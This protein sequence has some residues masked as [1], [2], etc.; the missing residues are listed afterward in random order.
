MKLFS[1]GTLFNLFYTKSQ[2]NDYKLISGMCLYPEGVCL[3]PYPILIHFCHV[4]LEMCRHGKLCIYAEWMNEINFIS[5]IFF[6]WKKRLHWRSCLLFGCA[7]QGLFMS[8]VC[9]RVDSINLP[10]PRRC[11]PSQEWYMFAHKSDSTMLVDKVVTR[12]RHRRLEIVKS[13]LLELQSFEMED[14]YQVSPDIVSMGNTDEALNQ[15]SRPS[16]MCSCSLS[17]RWAHPR[18]SVRMAKHLL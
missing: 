18:Q 17:H 6:W 15:S 3:N 12:L 10:E 4:Y 9:L 5:V 14:L 13:A 7:A 8:S 16:L 2:H 11:I 1:S